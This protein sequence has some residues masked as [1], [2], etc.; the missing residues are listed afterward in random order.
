MT[1]HR[2]AGL[3]RN[4]GPNAGTT[5]TLSE[6]SLSSEASRSREGQNHHIPTEQ[7]RDELG[8]NNEYQHPSIKTE[9]AQVNLNSYPQEKIKDEREHT[10]ALLVLVLL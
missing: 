7:L 6:Q 4:D 5:L 9:T 1:L 8:H 2:N 10:L 3:R